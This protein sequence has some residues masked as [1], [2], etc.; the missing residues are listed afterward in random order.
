MAETPKGFPSGR[1]SSEPLR[2]RERWTDRHPVD[3]SVPPSPA[4]HSSLP[5]RLSLTHQEISASFSEPAGFSLDAGSFPFHSRQHPW[6]QAPNLDLSSPCGGQRSAQV[7]S[8]LRGQN[9]LSPVS[10]QSQGPSSL[11]SASICAST[12]H[13]WPCLTSSQDDWETGQPEQQQK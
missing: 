13:L 5:Q 8:H 1:A 3:P 10:L 9:R 12:P 11:T 2:G 4:S 6:H 7:V